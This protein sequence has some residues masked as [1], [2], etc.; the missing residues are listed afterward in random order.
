MVN[1]SGAS[2]TDG[3]RKPVVSGLLAGMGR[4]KPNSIRQSGTERFLAKLVPNTRRVFLM[5]TRST[6]RTAVCGPACTVVWEGRAGN[7]SPYPDCTP[8]M[9]DSLEVEVLFTT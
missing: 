7:R 3:G 1:K 4:V 9:F 2:G 5:A 6:R 8:C